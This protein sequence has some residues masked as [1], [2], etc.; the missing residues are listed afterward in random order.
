MVATD[1]SP[2]NPRKALTDLHERKAA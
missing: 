1:A 2:H